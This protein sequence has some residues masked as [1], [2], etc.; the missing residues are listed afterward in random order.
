MLKKYFPTTQHFV[1]LSIGL[2]FMF[3]GLIKLNDPIGFALKIEAY[4]RAFASDIH[5]LFLQFL[6]YT[7][8]IAIA[9]CML[10]V[11]L[12]LALVGRFRTRLVVLALIGLTIFFTLLTGYTVWFKRIDSCGCLSEAI[13]L[14]PLQ[15]FLKNILLLFLLGWLVRK[16]SSSSNAT[17]SFTR[18]SL[19]TLMALGSLGLGLYVGRHLPII[20]FGRYRV[21]TYIPHLTQPQK[22]LRYQ[23]WLEKN[24]KITVSETYPVDEPCRLVKTELL[25][26]L[27]RPLVTNFTIWNE[28]REITQELLQGN[29]L[30]CIVKHP[31]RL[32]AQTYAILQ[33]YLQQSP[34][35]ID[36]LVLLPF[37][38]AKEALPS[39]ARSEVGW[40]S[41]DLLQSMIRSDVGFMLLQHGTVK[42]KWADTSLP[43]LYKALLQLR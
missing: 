30:I 37:H 43:S 5:N 36:M 28:D 9:V 25:N 13:P 12:G 2:F 23:Y 21:G 19:F 29:K 11:L 15:S 16:K 39:E 31:H 38:E 26:P 24:G 20:D 1:V 22:P 27:D 34:Q 41:A 7:L 33:T 17:T 14:T 18:I 40:G 3:S 35:A 4:L 6:P 32:A 42:G 10:E 8:P